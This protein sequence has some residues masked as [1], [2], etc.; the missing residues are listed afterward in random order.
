MN[1][2][3][4]VDFIPMT[5]RKAIYNFWLFS[6]FYVV[7]FFYSMTVRLFG[8]NHIK[9]KLLYILLKW[10][11]TTNFKKAF[12][13]FYFFIFKSDLSRFSILYTGVGQLYMY[14]AERLS[15]YSFRQ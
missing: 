10:V 8:T 15:L 11:Y 12:V 3:K 9:T 14:G 13:L 2:Y 7:F 4:T 6:S 5:K 1:R